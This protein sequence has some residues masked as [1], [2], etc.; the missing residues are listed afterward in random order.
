MI[1][2]FS[3]RWDD[4]IGGNARNNRNR[5]KMHWLRWRDAV[6]ATQRHFDEASPASR[7]IERCEGPDAPWRRWRRF[8][9]I[10]SVG[11]PALLIDFMPSK[12]K[13]VENRDSST[14]R[15]QIKCE[16]IEWSSNH[17]NHESIV[18][19]FKITNLTFL[20]IKIFLQIRNV[21]IV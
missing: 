7:R 18:N 4:F 8:L 13:R 14:G 21:W 16:L 15:S 2:V 6:G 12:S 9:T 10:T 5:L 17:S 11:F 19:F 3:C 1:G 20:Q